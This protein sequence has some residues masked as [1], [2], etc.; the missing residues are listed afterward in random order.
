MVFENNHCLGIFV[1][2]VIHYLLLAVAEHSCLC[3]KP[4][5][6]ASNITLPSLINLLTPFAQ[7]IR[8]RCSNCLV[9]CGFISA[10]D[11]AH[12]LVN[13]NRNLPTVS[14]DLHVYSKNQQ[15]RLYDCVKFESNN[16][17]IRCEQYR[18]HSTE[19]LSN[20]GIARKSIITNLSE[21]QLPILKLVGDRGG[22]TCS[23]EQYP[24]EDNGSKQSPDL[25]EYPGSIFI[26]RYLSNQRRSI[27]IKREKPMMHLAFDSTKY[28]AFINR[29]IN[30][31]AV[32]SGF[33]HSIVN[34][35]IRSS[36]IFYNISGDYRYCPKKGAHHRRNSVA[37][38]ID[39]VNDT[40]AIRCKDPNCDNTVLM[41]EKI[42]N[43]CCI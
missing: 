42:P 39:I 30:I 43:L 23:K 5:E 31:D 26:P 34:G 25:F 21:L 38:V 4:M 14:I 1:K 17:L 7:D 22:F 6:I 18:F 36:K 9:W 40:Y 15:I 19:L 12:L 11:I 13:D 35:N 2:S 3:F 27:Q 24:T 28:S 10:A 41:W 20:G 32:H 33:I 37:F 29:L 8:V 16:P